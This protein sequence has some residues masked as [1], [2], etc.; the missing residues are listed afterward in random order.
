MAHQ[1]SLVAG[2]VLQQSGA[3]PEAR[4]RTIFMLS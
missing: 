4:Y 3:P 2:G 1:A